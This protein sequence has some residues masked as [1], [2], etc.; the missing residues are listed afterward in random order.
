M[1]VPEMM[2]ERAVWLRGPGFG[3]ATPLMQG[4]DSSF[5][6][7]VLIGF[8]AMQDAENGVLSRRR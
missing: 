4:L 5:A 2:D 1:T 3:G 6:G 8:H 7:V